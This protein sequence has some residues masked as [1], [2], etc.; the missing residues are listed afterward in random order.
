MNK[1]FLFIIGN[2]L[3]LSFIQLLKIELF[4]G[5]ILGRIKFILVEFYDS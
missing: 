3:L 5:L 4:I 2:R 1:Y